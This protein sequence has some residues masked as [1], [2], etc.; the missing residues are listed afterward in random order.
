VLVV[1]GLG[2]LVV[3]LVAAFSSSAPPLQSATAPDGRPLPQVIAVQG[4]LRLQ[5][6]VGRPT[7]LGFHGSDGNS[8]PLQPVGRQGNEGVLTRMVHWLFGGGGSGPTYYLLGGGEGSGT[9][10]LDVGATEGTDVYSPVDG[11]VVSVGSYILDGRAY[12]NRLEIQPTEE[13]SV[14]VV[15]TRLRAD[16]SLAVG[17]P[18]SAGTSKIGE[19]ID[20]SAVETQTLAKV[21]HEA[22]NHVTI[23]IDPAAS[24]PVS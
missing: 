19:V 5:L 12:G 16:P 10:A 17:E 4:P 8:L 13:P 11:T 3:L 23:E 14:V 15:V 24:L 6:P 21:T 22:G 18:V 20:L 9:G 7:A 2:I 1:I